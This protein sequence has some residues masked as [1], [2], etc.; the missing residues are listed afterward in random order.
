[1]IL[2]W[3]PRSPFVRKVMICAHEL[4]LAERIEKVRSVTN[5][6]LPNEPLMQ[7][8]P[9]S[10]IPTLITDEG[11]A[12]IDSDVI[13]EY[14]NTL[15]RAPQLHPDGTTEKWRCLRWRAFGNEMLH[16]LILWRNERERPKDKAL[17]PLMTAFARKLEA[18]LIALEK[19]SAQLSSTPFSVGHIAIGT[20]L[21][22]LDLRFAELQWRQAVPGLSAW[23]EAFKGRPSVRATEPV[24]D[25]VRPAI[26][27]QP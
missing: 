8:N 19:E 25:Y 14:L 1:M 16:A 20:A 7:F 26:L 10:K 24:D 12:M 11:Q 9:W 4:G 6:L 17:A 13:C 15:Q 18:G 27:D 5:M 3:S 23:N 22:Y 21:G 2:H